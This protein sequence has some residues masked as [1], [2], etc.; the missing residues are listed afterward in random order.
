MIMFFAVFNQENWSWLLVFFYTT[1]ACI[2]LARFNVEQAGRAKHYFHGL[3]SPAAGL[4]LATYYRF[5]QTPLYQQ[6]MIAD[7]PWKVAL[8]ALMAL[9]SVLMISNIPYPAVPTVG[10]KT[11]R[12]ILG[13]LVV[14]V[15]ILGLL[16]IPKEFLFPACIAY[17]L[18]GMIKTGFLG[19]LGIRDT[20]L[21]AEVG[22][23]DD[24]DD[25]ENESRRP[26]H[27]E[28]RA[29]ITEPT[30]A[31]T[32]P[33]RLNVSADTQLPPSQRRRR[34]RRPPRGPRPDRSDD[35]GNP[36]PNPPSTPSG[37]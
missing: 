24:R 23:G 22:G 31:L 36:P 29:E 4:T 16:F 3:P 32:S 27:V 19:L 30:I 13:T 10:Y 33:P 37:D 17:V 25:M 2:R 20:A 14:G 28:P 7:V 8:P 15:A 35:S 12:E 18:Y 26:S 5:S 1:C 6:T 11:K 21:I 9:L 34:R